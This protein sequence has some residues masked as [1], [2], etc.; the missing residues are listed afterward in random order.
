MLN[1]KD[2]TTRS[3]ERVAPPAVVAPPPAA[4]L[5]ASPWWSIKTLSK[6]VYIYIYMNYRPRRF[7]RRFVPHPSS[8][9]SFSEPLLPGVNEGY[10]RNLKG[11]V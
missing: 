2:T 4:E 10:Y 7:S 1:L 6:K 11:M 3:T 9:S 5:A 8:A